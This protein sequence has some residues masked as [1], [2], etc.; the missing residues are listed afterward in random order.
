MTAFP[1]RPVGWALAILSLSLGALLSGW[2]GPSFWFAFL[3][4][5]GLGAAD[6]ARC[7]RRG[8]AR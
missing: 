6:G 4:L 2:E 7:Q 8:A 1:F 3:G 5:V